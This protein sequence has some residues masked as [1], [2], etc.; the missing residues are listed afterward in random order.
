MPNT[1]RKTGFM[2]PGTKLALLVM[3]ALMVGLKLVDTLVQEG[4]V[5]SPSWRWSLYAGLCGGVYAAVV[6]AYRLGL[7][8]Q[9]NDATK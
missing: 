6:N 7:G 9:G 5:L 8:N 1:T 3:V 2:N 4:G